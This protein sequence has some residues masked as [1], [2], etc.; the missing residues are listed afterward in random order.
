MAIIPWWI[1]GGAMLGREILNWRNR[2]KNRGRDPNA[3][4][5]QETI[6]QQTM[7]PEQRQLRSQE[8]NQ[9]IQMLSQPQ[10]IYRNRPSLYMQTPSGQID[11]T[12]NQSTTQAPLGGLSRRLLNIERANM[13]GGLRG[14]LSQVENLIAGINPLGLRSS[15]RQAL[16]GEAFKNRFNQT[17]MG[18]MGM[19]TDFATQNR[20]NRLSGQRLGRLRSQIEGQLSGDASSLGRESEGLDQSQ[21][22][23]Q[24]V[25][26]AGQ[27]N[28]LNELENQR[29]AAA[30]RSYGFGLRPSLRTQQSPPLLD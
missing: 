18:Q 22:M 14:D 5:P 15:G 29:R 16:R 20:L 7:T 21:L 11:T 1:Y 10:R 17:L 9:A 13:G 6:Q 25:L 27:I 28:M 4:V 24:R 26:G 3:L 19:L 23:A 2:L 30:N 12:I 8:L